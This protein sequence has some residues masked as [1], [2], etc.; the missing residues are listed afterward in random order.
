MKQSDLLPRNER[1]ITQDEV[2][3]LISDY[4]VQ[5]M[6]PLSTVEKPAFR[7]MINGLIAMYKYLVAKL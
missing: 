3:G 4:I 6:R 2:D 1:S 5:E 7:K